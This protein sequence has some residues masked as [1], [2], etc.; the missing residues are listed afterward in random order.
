VPID[1]LSLRSANDAY[2]AI[3]RDTEPWLEQVADV[4]RVLAPSYSKLL[5]QVLGRPPPGST[6]SA[7][8]ST[9]LMGNRRA[10]HSFLVPAMNSR[11][12]LAQPGHVASSDWARA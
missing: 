2:L 7:Q 4:N 10:A 12:G 9:A 1:L 11:G 3:L 6:R 5:D 8:R